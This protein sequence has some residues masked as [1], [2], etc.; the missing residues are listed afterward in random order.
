MT[1]STDDAYDGFLGAIPY[2]FRATDSRLCRVYVVV[3]TAIATLVALLF[4][5]GVVQLLGSGF[6]GSGG[7]VLSTRAFYIVLA[8]FLVGPLLAPTLL[9]ARRHRHG[10]AN[11]RYDRAIAASGFLFVA[12][13]Y[14]GLVAS[15]PPSFELDGETVTRPPADG[16][17]A[18]LLE[19]LYA[20][21]EP[22]W[23]AVP[24]VAAAVMVLVHLRYR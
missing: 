15:M 4:G 12:S 17:A 5:L 6:V 18:P 9:V 14:L 11:A 8:L 21:P 3:G 1:A 23:P 22:A 16:L 20:I 19:L 10:R 2:A 24:T 7:L 13:L